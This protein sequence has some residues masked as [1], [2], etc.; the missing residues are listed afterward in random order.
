[1]KLCQSLLKLQCPLLQVGH[2]LNGVCVKHLA[3][4]EN[5]WGTVWIRHHIVPDVR[6][7]LSHNQSNFQVH[8]LKFV[9][10][11]FTFWNWIFGWLLRFLGFVLICFSIAA[12]LALVFAFFGLFFAHF[13]HLLHLLLLQAWDLGII[14]FFRML[15]LLLLLL[16]FSLFF[17]MSTSSQNGRPCILRSFIS[18]LCSLISL[19]FS[20]LM[21]LLDCVMFGVLFLMVLSV[22]FFDN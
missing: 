4:V 18:L 2:K 22:D 14:I 10:I 8:W 9:T 12:A 5:L 17:L 11:F 19:F 6:L 13:L 15:E 21:N 3:S 16:F 1:M 7:V 20:A